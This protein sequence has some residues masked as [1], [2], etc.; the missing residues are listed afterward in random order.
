MSVIYASLKFRE[1]NRSDK[2]LISPI[3]SILRGECVSEGLI[4]LPGLYAKSHII[5]ADNL[6]DIISLVN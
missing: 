4:T 2:E 1:Q 3:L 5:N 6:V